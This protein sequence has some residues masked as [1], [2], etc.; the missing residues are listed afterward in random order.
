MRENVCIALF[1]EFSLL[2]RPTTADSAIPT[3][4]NTSEILFL[5]LKRKN[6]SLGNDRCARNQIWIP[7]LTKN[8]SQTR[9][10]AFQFELHAIDIFRFL[11][12]FSTTLVMEICFAFS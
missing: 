1:V 5:F 11:A 9:Q 2:D 3:V 8:I 6:S 12:R 7:K 10:S 4:L